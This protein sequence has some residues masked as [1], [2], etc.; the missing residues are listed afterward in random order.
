[1]NIKKAEDTSRRW[2][3]EKFKTAHPFAGNKK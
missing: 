2:Q 3:I 1:M